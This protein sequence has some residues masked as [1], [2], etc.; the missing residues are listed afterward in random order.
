V[1][2]I[3][4]WKKSRHTWYI[5]VS[6]HIH[7]NVKP[8][9]NTREFEGTAIGELILTTR[10]H[11]KRTH[12]NRMS[13]LFTSESEYVE[14]CYYFNFQFSSIENY[15][16]RSPFSDNLSH[17]FIR[18]YI[19]FKHIL[20]LLWDFILRERE[21]ERENKIHK[22]TYTVEVFLIWIFALIWNKMHYFKY[23]ASLQ[24]E[25]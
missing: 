22:F 24:S 8:V 15:S 1:S 6:W 4:F 9:K 13:Y 23:E 5:H 14:N 19:Q 7:W 2:I 3:Y 20:Q 25:C 10:V 11:F 12:F 16:I 18:Y 21:R 17:I